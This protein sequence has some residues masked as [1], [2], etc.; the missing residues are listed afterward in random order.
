MICERCGVDKALADFM[1]YMKGGYNKWCKPCAKEYIDANKSRR[2]RIGGSAIK[3]RNY[4]INASK[5]DSRRDVK[6]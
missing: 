1:Q 4:F 5:R 2:A 3:K 6:E